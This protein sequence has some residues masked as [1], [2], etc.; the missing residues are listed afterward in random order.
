MCAIFSIFWKKKNYMDPH[1]W[2]DTHILIEIMLT[3]IYIEVESI[4]AFYSVD[5]I[6]V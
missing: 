2:I 6:L 5:Y 4:N 3:K 1:L